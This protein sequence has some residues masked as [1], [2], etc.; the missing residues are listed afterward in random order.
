[1]LIENKI[2]IEAIKT[3]DYLFGEVGGMVVVSTGHVMV[4]LNEKDCLLDISKQKKI[5]GDGLAKYDPET[6]MENKRE[7]KISHRLID[8]GCGRMFLGVVDK[9]TGEYAWFN[10]KYI[11]MFSDCTIWL[12]RQEDYYYAAFTRYGK[13]VGI[14]MPVRVSEGWV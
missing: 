6:I 9:E 1:M 10:R 5:S 8:E 7:A 11:K 3:R 2:Q 14:V 13:L 12:V 4:Y